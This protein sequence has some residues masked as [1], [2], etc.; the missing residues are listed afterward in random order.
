VRQITASCTNILLMLQTSRTCMARSA[1]RAASSTAQ[2][3]RAFSSRGQ[4]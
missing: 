1:V 2:A 4:S 3:G